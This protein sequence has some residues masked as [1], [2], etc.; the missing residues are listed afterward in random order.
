MVGCTVGHAEGTRVGVMEG[1]AV[2]GVDVGF[3]VGIHV[4]VLVEGTVVGI[5]D[6]VLDGAAVVGTTVG[7]TLGDFV[8]IN[9]RPSTLVTRPPK[10]LT[11]TAVY[12]SLLLTFRPDDTTDTESSLWL[13]ISAACPYK[14]T[15]IITSPF[16]NLYPDIVIAVLLPPITLDGTTENIIPP[17]NVVSAQVTARCCVSFTVLA[18]FFST[19]PTAYPSSKISGFDQ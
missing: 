12:M 8:P 7:T 14:V 15:E 18:L 17:E 16:A 5:I 2:D 19:E 11:T 1:R 13:V 9:I 6:G 4:G 10:V 3:F